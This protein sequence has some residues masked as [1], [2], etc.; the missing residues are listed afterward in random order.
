MSPS[1][2]IAWFAAGA[3]ALAAAALAAFP[4]AAFGD[5]LDFLLLQRGGYAP[6]AIFRAVAGIALTAALVAAIRQGALPS[7][8]RRGRDRLAGAPGTYAAI[9][10]GIAA[11]AFLSVTL[12]AS[13]GACLQP[14]SESYL[15]FAPHRTIGYP[16]FLRLVTGEHDDR[17]YLAAAQSAFLL[18]GLAALAHQVGRVCEDR[19]AAAAGFALMAGNA[20]LAGYA[21]FVLAETPFAALLAFHLAA[22][23]AL[24]VRFGWGMALA[25]GLAL[26]GAI[27]MRPAGYAFLGALPAL[28][29]LLARR[30]IL[31]TLAVAAGAALPLLG[32]SAAN[33]SLHGFFATQ[34][35][36][37]YSLL[38]HTAHLI[39]P[40]MATEF[41]GLPERIAAGTAPFRER[42]D[43]A[44]FPHAAWRVGMNAYNPQ[45]YDVTLPA[46]EA[47]LA[48]R[49][50]QTRPAIDDLVGRLAREAIVNDPAGYARQV[51]AHYYGLWLLSFLPH[52]PIASR[53]RTCL[54]G[55]A[56][57]APAA[58]PSSPV[59]LFWAVATLSQFP[60]AV[61]ALLA[62]WLAIPAWFVA[63]RRR[64]AW[65]LAIYAALGVNAYFL[66]FATTQVALPRYAVVVEPWLVA[67]LIAL[68]ASSVQRH[69]QD[70]HRPAVDRAR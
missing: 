48:E 25:A 24:C 68:A 20:S 51:A 19:L 45:L 55:A 33:L 10:A 32:A 61:V 58:D 11:I 30:R 53:L 1:A 21:G 39:V 31:G 42:I 5:R 60:A 9:L 38:G 70:G 18:G 4:P 22:V 65:R 16:A 59:D 47:W 43:A 56:G 29:L 37:G 52:G 12:S 50:E 36:G 14:D 41:D 64:P 66:G 28:L 7:L 13:A 44:S 3:F 57:S 23:A 46:I 69:A 40:G 15:T 67:L 27:L 54:D 17:T 49:P 35:I 63:A 8:W 26:G 2:K 6:G 62:C 34:S